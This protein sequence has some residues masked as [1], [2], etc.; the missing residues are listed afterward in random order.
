MARRT[1]HYGRIVPSG[2]ETKYRRYY[3]L[4]KKA[5][6]AA[7]HGLVLLRRKFT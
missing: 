4:H 3:R 5:P 2:V 1:Y 6:E 7:L